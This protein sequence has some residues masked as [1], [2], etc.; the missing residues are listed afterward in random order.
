MNKKHLGVLVSTLTV[1]GAEQLLLELLRHINR[2]KFNIHVFFLQGRGLLGQELEKLNIPTSV[3]IRKS[4]L[5]P[6]TIARLRKIFV[7]KNIDSLLLINH[8]DAL[9]Y[10]VIAARLAGVRPIVNWENETF[11]PYTWHRLTMLARRLVHRAVDNVVAAAQGHKDYIARVERLPWQKICVIYNGVD[12][13]KFHSELSPDQARHKIGLPGECQV[14][15]IIAVLRPDKAHEI[16]LQAARLILD[17][18]PQTHFLIIG[19]GP[20]KA[21]LQKQAREMDMQAQVHFLGF[22]RDLHDI[23]PAVDVNVLSSRPM[24]ETLSVAAIEAMSA[25]IPMVCTRV[26]FMDEIVINDETGYLVEV[27]D[28]LALAE[29]TSVILNNDTLREKMS[30]NAS[31]LV[32]DQ[33]SARQ[34]AL[35]F[36]KLYEDKT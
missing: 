17:K 8:R 33:L 26:G 18:L 7:Q 29:K 19:D 5:D 11:K 14:V 4:R 21:E 2:A 25:G 15:S 13:E 16:F 3:D 31:R 28:A 9:C 30:Q 34:M 6:F 22:R 23:F 20:R 12:P 24:Q 32:A 36:E 27:D 10:G 1:G 35:S